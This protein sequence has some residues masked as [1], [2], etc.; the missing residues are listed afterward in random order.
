M[1]LHSHC[2][3]LMASLL[4][5]LYHWCCVFLTRYHTILFLL[6]SI[7]FLPVGSLSWELVVPCPTLCSEAPSGP[8]RLISHVATTRY[9]RWHVRLQSAK[10]GGCLAT[11]LQYCYVTGARHPN[12]SK[13]PFL[14][15]SHTTNA[16]TGKFKNLVIAFSMK[17]FYQLIIIGVVEH[18]W[19]FLKYQGWIRAYE[20]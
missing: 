1:G 18:V 12:K 17:M 7:L 20:T 13:H 3:C 5:Q 19:I 10:P 15:S 11:G 16:K 6:I 4:T 2:L 8:W 14:L 9:S